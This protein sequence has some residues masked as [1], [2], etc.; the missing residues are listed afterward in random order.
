[1]QRKLAPL[2]VGIK[3]S[4]SHFTRIYI[5]K[6]KQAVPTG[7]NILEYRSQAQQRG[8]LNKLAMEKKAQ[9]LAI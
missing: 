4:T 9:Q 7:E 2:V 5:L 3:D 6:L 8:S 1:M